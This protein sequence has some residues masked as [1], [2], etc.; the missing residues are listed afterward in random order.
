MFHIQDL[1]IEIAN[2]HAWTPNSK[3]SVHFTI[4]ILQVSMVMDVGQGALI[5]ALALTAF[6]KGVHRLTFYCIAGDIEEHFY[7]PT[8][9][10]VISSYVHNLGSQLPFRSKTC[11]SGDTS[12]YAK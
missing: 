9:H 7:H 3:C 5:I 2:K 12:L 6:C 10:K 11:I 8:P 4:R 1:C